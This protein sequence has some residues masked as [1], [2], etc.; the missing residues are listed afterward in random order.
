[1]NGLGNW[2]VQVEYKDSGRQWIVC[3]KC[4]TLEDMQE[5]NPNIVKLISQTWDVPGL[6][7]SVRYPS[8]IAPTCY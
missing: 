4:G 2:M 3:N 7:K 5:Q 1:M 8:C 6:N